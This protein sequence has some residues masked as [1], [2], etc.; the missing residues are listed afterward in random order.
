MRR[1]LLLL[2]VVAP[3]AALLP[4]QA[5]TFTTSGVGCPAPAPPQL[6]VTNLPTLGGT[7]TITV[8]GLPLDAVLPIAWIGGAT[9]SASLSGIGATGCFQM[10]G[11][12][13]KSINVNTST[14][15]GTAALALPVSSAF[16]GATFYVQ[17]AALSPSSNSF[18]LTVSDRGSLTIGSGVT[19]SV[20]PYGGAVVDGVS[21]IT[22]VI[23]ISRTSGEVPCVVQATAAASSATW[24]DPTTGV[25]GPLPNPYDQIHYTWDFG[26][27]AA[28]EVLMHPVSGM[29]VDADRHQ[30]GPQATFIYRRPG[31][32]TARLTASIKDQFG[33]VTQATTGVIITVSDFGGQTRYFDPVNGSDLNDGLSSATPMQSWAAYSGWVTGGDHRRAL[34]KRGTT[35]VQTGGF[36]ND[37]SHTRVEPYG[38]GAPPTIQASAGFTGAMVAATSA[39]FFEDQLYSGVRFLGMGYA[40]RVVLVVGQASPAAWDLVFM[41]CTFQN[42]QPN[43]LNLVTM[44]GDHLSRLTFWDCEFDHGD[45]GGHALYSFMNGVTQPAEYLSVVGGSITGGG[46][47]AGY[48]HHIYSSGWRNYDLFR[49][50]DFGPSVSKNFC[51]N[52]NCAANGQDTDFMLIDGCDVTGCTNGI[53]ASNGQNNPALG[54]FNHFIIQNTAV[55]HCGAMQGYGL[56]GYAVNRYVVRDSFFYANPRSDLRISDPGVN[57]Q[58]YRSTF[59]RSEGGLSTSGV[60]LRS[61]QSGYFVDNIFENASNPGHSQRVID[62]GSTEASNYTFAGNQYWSPYLYSSGQVRPFKDRDSS[63]HLTMGQWLA[64]FPGDGPY[65]DPGFVNPASGVF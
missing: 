31:T 41:H 62:I 35:L 40:E 54:Q 5:G 3:M 42:S 37:C 30:T 28:T 47:S 33:V 43:G 53:D 61:G 58:V 50:V 45:A 52:M 21:G 13:I 4:A 63:Q 26:D 25:A 2:L 23:T 36:S 38:A 34:L 59:W 15:G 7:T 60:R 8:N 51:I 24:T 14:G 46:N 49:W 29:T 27:G 1:H 9:T 64:L 10:I 20:L 12:I 11:N 19:P 65:A 16:V 6:S 32:Y 22:P 48:D 56:M 44:T 55:H 18:G 39:Q 57:Y 17:A